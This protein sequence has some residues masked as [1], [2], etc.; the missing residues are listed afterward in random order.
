MQLL[1]IAMYNCCDYGLH[2]GGRTHHSDHWHIRE[3]HLSAAPS[4]A[5]QRG[6]LPGHPVPA[7]PQRVRMDL[8]EGT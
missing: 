4:R 7:G 8:W 5:G 1:M 6:V 3:L 2:S